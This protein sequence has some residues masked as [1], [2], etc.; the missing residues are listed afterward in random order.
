V[1][2]T[3]RSAPF[4][5]EALALEVLAAH[6]AHETVGVVVLVERLHPPVARLYGQPTAHAFGGEE[7]IPVL[8]TVGNAVCQIEGTVAEGLATV[9]AV[10][11]LRVPLLLQRR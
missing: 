6:G 8:L 2:F 3:E 10:E 4:G 1:R 9:A 7:F 11:A 5:V